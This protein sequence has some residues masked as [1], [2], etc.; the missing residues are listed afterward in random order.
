MKKIF[1]QL[2]GMVT[3]GL[4]VA[5]LIAELINLISFLLIWTAGWIVYNL[6]FKN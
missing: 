4:S 1:L 3:V 6:N 5:L 2:V